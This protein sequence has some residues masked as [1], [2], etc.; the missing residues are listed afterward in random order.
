MCG[1]G[2]SAANPSHSAGDWS[3]EIGAR[4]QC[5]S[6]NIASM[7]AWANDSDYSKIFYSSNYKPI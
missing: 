5:L 3:K 6:D 2:G 1:N 4:T 7:T